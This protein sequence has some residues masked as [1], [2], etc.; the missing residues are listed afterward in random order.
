[1][2]NYDPEWVAILE[3]NELPRKEIR[4]PVLPTDS[5]LYVHEPAGTAADQTIARLEHNAWVFEVFGLDAEAIEKL[6]GPTTRT[7]ARSLEAVAADA[8]EES[9]FPAML[10]RA[11]SADRNRGKYRKAAFGFTQE[12]RKQFRDPI[13]EEI[14][15]RFERL[16]TAMVD[17][18]VLAVVEG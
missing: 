12:L 10:K 7:T 9:G 11:E 15:E 8:L 1:M 3:L 13:A 6:S 18:V 14:L 16:E 17:G 4:P 5:E 2:S